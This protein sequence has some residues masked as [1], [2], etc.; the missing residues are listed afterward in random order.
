MKLP[1]I[2]QILRDARRSLLRFPLV[3]L[4]A[5][6][7]TAAV[8]V[9]IDYEGPPQPTFLFQVLF[10]A[11]LGFPLLAG[12]ALTAERRRWG[13]SVSLGSQLTGVI[14]V[15]IYAL[16]VPSQL[17][18]AP[19]VHIIRLVILTVGLVLFAF[20]GPYLI[21]ESA[22]GFWQYSKTLLIRL[23]VAYLY[24]AVLWAGLAVAL[25]ALDNL[26][27]IDVPMKRY[28]ELWV[29]IQG[30]FTPWF[31]LAGIPE[32][33][34]SMDA[35]TDYPKSLKLF[36]QYIVFPL[37][38]T[39]FVILYAYIG[40][41]VI[42][43]DWPQGWVSK[44]I[45]GFIATGFVWMILLDPIRERAE[46]R[47]IKITSRWFFLLC[48]PLVVMLFLA[49]LRRLSEYGITEGRYLAIALGIW[50]CMIV[51][52]FVASKK[53]NILMIPATLCLASFL[54]S[55]GPWSVFAV[56][57]QS[58]IARLKVMLEKNKI[59]VNE[60]VRSKHDSIPDADRRQISSILYY[61]SS[62]HGYG[63]IQA[64]FAE[65]LK[66]DSLSSSPIY[67]DPAAVASLM[68]IEYIRVWQNPTGGLGVLNADREHSR[69]ISGYGRMLR[70]QRLFQEG[71]PAIEAGDVRYHMEPG[72]F[73][74]NFAVK[75]PG[76]A[77]DSIRVDFRQTVE[78]LVKNYG[79]AI[80]ER[81]PPE[82][83][84]VVAADARLRVKVNFWQIRIKR[85]GEVVVPV[86]YD[87]DILFEVSKGKDTR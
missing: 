46:N 8:L 22:L 2:D 31:F 35:L 84:T 73:V 21:R 28:G 58:Q 63:G 82:E 60:V 45:L 65:S 51:P 42:T 71:G 14:L 57:E 77:I 54:V 17:D 19:L 39:Y 80:T 1:T 86:S 4:A 18:G 75:Q 15:S 10:A 53:K 7:G 68:G 72:M 62:F 56:S 29:F 74:L 16:F 32:D 52:Y 13:S 79:T 5:F 11:I 49:L 40:K 20:V 48:M 3:L 64:W 36:S 33:L 76:G 69:D 78:R 85:Q 6:A 23:V 83:L 61:L 67:R 55:F 70:A 66:K 44:L 37:V 47:W 38:I 30:V 9:L 41:I 50:L 81:I 34:G 12:L 24:G 59:L 26:F 27:G 87:A 43:W 25:A